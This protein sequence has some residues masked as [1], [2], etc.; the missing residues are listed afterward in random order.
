MQYVTFAEMEW[1]RIKERTV[2]GREFTS[3][4]DIRRRFEGMLHRLRHG[5]TWGDMPLIRGPVD[6]IRV[7][8]LS[9]WQKGA[10]PEVVRSL[11]GDAVGV[12]AYRRP[13]LPP[14][15]VTAQFGAGA[16]DGPVPAR[17]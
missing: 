15:V 17:L 11:G 2:A 5:L 6:P 3:R 4:Y 12:A 1:R 8:Q 13:S 10:W 9:W 14:L 16:R 7:W